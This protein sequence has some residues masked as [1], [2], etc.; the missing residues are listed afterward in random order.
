MGPKGAEENRAEQSK[1][2][3][4]FTLYFPAHTS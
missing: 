1:D 4:W 3:V 2:H